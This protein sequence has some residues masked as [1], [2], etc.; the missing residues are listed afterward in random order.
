MYRFQVLSNLTARLSMA[1]QLGMQYGG[2]RNM[3]DVLG[4]PKDITFDTYYLFFKRHDIA[5][6]VINR[7]I[8]ASWRGPVSPMEMNDD[9]DTP[10]ELAWKALMEE[11]KTVKTT[12]IKADRL[13]GLGRFGG[14]LLGL[15]DITTVQDYE[16]PV[17]GK[18]KLVYL[19]A[20]GENTCTIQE[21]EEDPRN[22]RY[23]LP[24]IYLIS[25]DTDKGSTSIKVHH[26]RIIH[27]V[28]ESVDTDVYGT[29]RL[30]GIFNRLMDLEKLVG[31]S[32]EMFWKGA[33]PGYSAAVEPNFQMTDKEYDELKTQIDEYEH[34]LRRILVNQGTKLDSLAQQ[35]ADPK[36]HVDVQIQMISAV[37]G[38]PKRILTGSERGELA[39]SQDQDEWNAYIQDRRENF[40]EPQILRPFVDKLIEL[41]ILPKPQVE[42]SVQ[43]QDLHA[44][45]DEDKA[46][47]GEIR[48]RAL[49][50]YASQPTAEM[51]VPP[52]AFYEFFLGF[53]Q[54]QIALLI[55]MQEQHLKEVEMQDE[56]EESPDEE[57]EE[58]DD[59]VEEMDEEIDEPE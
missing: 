16:Y 29:P 24:K 53:S 35:V 36:N 9:K 23:G 31:G 13:T 47:V 5:K 46:R 19:K 38:I 17:S 44:T 32:A 26:T 8:K 12:L 6:A 51:L 18:R 58:E 34:N 52:L 49:K 1:S 54:E 3:Y 28:D 15:D 33:R 42:Y 2:N 56:E 41:G 30:E 48:A 37:T 21:W 50:E 4:Y 10:F 20:F 14:I 43:W 45:S 7:P 22:P 27:I 55:Q 40:I 57:M 25:V 39:S 11:H 59:D